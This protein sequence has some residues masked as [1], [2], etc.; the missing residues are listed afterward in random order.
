MT[1]HETLEAQILDSAPNPADVQTLV[2][3][4]IQAACKAR[5]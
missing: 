4:V 3:A 2:Q 1:V 5:E